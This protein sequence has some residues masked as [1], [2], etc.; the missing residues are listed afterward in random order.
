MTQLIKEGLMDQIYNILRQRIINLQLKPGAKID[1]GKIA[2]EFDISE[3]PIRDALKKLSKDGLVK[4]ESRRG[5][6][7]V[8]L[9]KRDIE[10]IYDL[11]KL[12]E[13]YAFSSS[14][15][16]IKSS[17]LDELRDMWINMKNKGKHRI[18]PQEFYLTD[19]EFHLKIVKRCENHWLQNIFFQIYDL[20]RICQHMYMDI[21]SA[22]D[23]HIA[24]VD[25]I[26]EKD[27][28]K[29]KKLLEIHI[30]RAKKRILR[31]MEKLEEN[32]DE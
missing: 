10:E 15:N 32:I 19:Q 16:N 4:I 20:V 2:T 23:E 28:D 27:I 22:L 7:V 13:S 9:S 25:A 3:T 6:Y 17:E 21:K 18:D 12:L 26:K 14:I 31:S 1:I 24:I 8:K 11:R 29:A 5:Y 30:D